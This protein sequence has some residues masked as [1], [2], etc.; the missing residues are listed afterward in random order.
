MVP[1]TLNEAVAA[2][3]AVIA[4]RQVRAVAPANV[5]EA[6]EIEIKAARHA[7]V[8]SLRMTTP[9][10]MIHTVPGIVQALA[11]PDILAPVALEA[12]V[13]LLAIPQVIPQTLL[14]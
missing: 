12:G 9:V 3:E 1:S 5:T 4:V 11:V 7:L 13:G 8:R 6:E 2:G 10:G 14:L